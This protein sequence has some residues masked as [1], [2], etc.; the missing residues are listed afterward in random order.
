MAAVY[1][2][3]DKRRQKVLK[4]VNDVRKE[5]FVNQVKNYVDLHLDHDIYFP[6]CVSSFFFFVLDF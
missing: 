1:L 6:V 5:W 4:W 2:Y 3:G